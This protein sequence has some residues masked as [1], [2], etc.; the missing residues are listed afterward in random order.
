[1]RQ[2]QQNRRGRSRS[3]NSNNGSSSSHTHNRKGGQN[4]LTRSFESTGPDTKIR[5][6]PAHIA[7]KY[8]VLARDAQSSGDPV[9]AE[10]YL[11]HAEHYNRIIMAYREQ[12][13]QSGEF[14]NGGQPD[15]GRFRQEGMGGDDIG[16]GDGGEFGAES[17]SQPVMQQ[18]DAQPPAPMQP[19]SFENKRFE[20]RG[21]QQGQEGYRNNRPQQPHR[22]RSGG[23]PQRSFSQDRPD[24]GQDRGQDRG[25]DRAPDR[26]ER[27]ERFDRGDRPER[28]DRVE[29]N[30]RSEQRLDRQPT[31]PAPE[32]Q[33]DGPR[34]ANRERVAPPSHEQPEFLRRPVRRPRPADT[35]EPAAAAPPAVDESGRD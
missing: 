15:G 23:D 1:M 8:M 34:R 26:G 24:R 17:Q 32:G 7:E 11:Q 25:P 22:D 31:Q 16:E 10:N 20:D 27:R 30:D 28:N 18:G 12:A 35:E 14:A 3:N 5:G 19:R 6:T 2:G 4:P 29:R 9:L 21:P 33:A 13:P